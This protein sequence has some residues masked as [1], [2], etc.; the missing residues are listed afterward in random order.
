M[1]LI[2]QILSIISLGYNSWKGML[3]LKETK[4]GKYV[5]GF[6]LMPYIIYGLYKLS[7]DEE[8]ARLVDKWEREKI[9]YYF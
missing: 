2:F 6:F 9:T 5:I 1:D 3:W 8:W 7:K 4:V